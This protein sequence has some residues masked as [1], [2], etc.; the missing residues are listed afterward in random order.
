MLASTIAAACP[1]CGS[2]RLDTKG[3]G[4][5][6]VE[7]EA[8]KLFEGAR[9]L[10]M[11]TDTTGGKN[12]YQNLIQ[13]F[14]QRRADILIGTQMIAKGL[15]FDNVSVVGILNADNAF[16]SP[17]FRA[18]ERGFQLLSQVAGR[19]GRKKQGRVVIQT[20]EPTHEVIRNV[21]TSDYRAMYR[22]VLKQ[23]REFGYPPFRRMVRIVLRHKTPQTLDD[24]AGLLAAR[25]RELFGQNVLGPDYYYIPRI[26]NY[27]IQHLYVKLSDSLSLTGA[28]S[29]IR[30]A[31]AILTAEKMFRSVRI[32]I[33]VDPQ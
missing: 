11:D 17:D 23:R 33:D 29:A 8:E 3:F 10:R 32:T 5:Q 1:A 20:Y 18:F 7:A 15:D 26:N 28:K 21:L 19:A 22:E 30:R 12:S 16:K 9:I 25:M 13:A 31:A 14:E 24:A 6:Q 4:T 27:F 2:P